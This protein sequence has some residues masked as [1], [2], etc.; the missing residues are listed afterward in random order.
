[1][2]ITDSLVEFLHNSMLLSRSTIILTDLNKVVFVASNDDNNYLNKNLHDNMKKLLSLYAA[3]SCYIDY[4][5]ISM[6]TIVPIVED[7][8]ILKYESQIVLPIIHNNIVDRFAYFCY[9]Y[10][11]IPRFKFKVC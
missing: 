4:M 6:D 8:D 7:D 11:E 5:N 10:K 2:Y 1:M 9:W 3:D